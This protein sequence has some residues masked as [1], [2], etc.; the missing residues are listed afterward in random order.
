[1]H[2]DIRRLAMNVGACLAAALAGPVACTEVGTDPAA[3][4]ALELDPPVVPAIVAGDSLRDSTGKAVALSARA[5]NASNTVIPGAR[6][7]F[8]V[9]GDTSVARVDSTSGLVVGLK[10][11]ETSVVASVG[12]LQSARVTIRVTL[13]PD[14]LVPLDSLRD[15]LDIVFGQDNLKALRVSLRSDTTPAVTT[16][17]LL[18]VAN[19]EVRFEIVAPSG[20]PVD[21]TTKVLLVNDLKRPS[22]VDTTDASGIASRQLRLSPAALSSIPDSVVVRVSAFRPDRTPVPGSPRHFV[23]TL[24]AAAPG[25][26]AKWWPQRRSMRSLR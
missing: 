25:F 23:I 1:M 5:F 22:R 10:P 8:L 26:N 18:P 12:S 4:V 7:T 17:S 9:I 14:S 3:V 6:I 20:L 16:D 19:Y 21:D 15:T 2:S 24:R 11:G 13:R